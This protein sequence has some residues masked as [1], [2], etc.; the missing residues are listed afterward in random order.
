M[1]NIAVLVSGDGTNL[2]ALLDA[3]SNGVIAQGRIRLVVSNR[4]DAG[5][6]SRAARSGKKSVVIPRDDP[7]LLIETICAEGIDLIVLC[8]YLAL[9][10]ESL[11]RMY[12]NRVINIHPALMPLFSG[13][14]FYGIKVHEAVIHSGMKVTG[15]TV[16]YADEVF[17]NGPII[18]QRAVLV[19]PDDTPETLRQRVLNTEHEVLVET[20]KAWTEGRVVSEGGKAWIIKGAEYIKRSG[21]IC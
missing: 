2:Q 11:I 1:Y 21:P 9:L 13:K 12:P 10:P 4:K 5:G 6:L 19:L 17:D 18:E 7:E 20:V 14:G 16:H 15:V 8:G 3:E